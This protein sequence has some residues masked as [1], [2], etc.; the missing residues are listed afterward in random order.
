MIRQF[1]DILPAIHPTAFI[2]DD[3]LIIG[4]VEIG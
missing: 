1:N 4:D 2:A 3:A